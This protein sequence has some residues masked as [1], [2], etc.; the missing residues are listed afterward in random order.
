MYCS[1]WWM[2]K[3]HTVCSLYNT[4]LQ[5]HECHTKKG[6][7]GI[8]PSNSPSFGMAMTRDC[9]RR[10]KLYLIVGAISQKTKV[11]LSCFCMTW[12]MYGGHVRSCRCLLMI[13]S[14]YINAESVSM[15]TCQQMTHYSLSAANL[16]L[17]FVLLLLEVED[18][19][20]RTYIACIEKMKMS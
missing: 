20:M 3:G 8:T 11:C 6:L 4:F 9:T 18:E 17:C 19:L 1:S 15:E 16:Y 10:L 7:A 2:I 12:Y 14:H 5:C 13:S